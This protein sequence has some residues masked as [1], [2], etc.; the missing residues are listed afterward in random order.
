MKDLF[1]I[2]AITFATC[3]SLFALLISYAAY[4]FA[5]REN[6]YLRERIESLE[7]KEKDHVKEIKPLKEKIELLEGNRAFQSDL[8]RLWNAFYAFK[9]RGK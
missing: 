2:L 4:K 6:E 3:F 8:K 9:N 1:I 7:E 5:L